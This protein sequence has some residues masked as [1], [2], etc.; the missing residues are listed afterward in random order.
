M[1]RPALPVLLIVALAIG[2]VP[3]GATTPLVPDSPFGTPTAV[4]AT[5]RVAFAPA[6]TEVAAR[7][8]MVGRNLV[9]AN[10]Q[11]GVRPLFRT[12]GSPEPEIFHRGT[13]EI[14]IS[15]GLAKQC[16]TDA[17]LTAVLSHELGKLVS[18][19]EALAGPR[20]R[21]SQA[22]PPPDVPVGNLDGSFSGAADQTRLAELARYKPSAYRGP[23]PPPPDPEELAKVYLH[24]AG[25][26][27]EELQAVAPWLKAAAVNSTLERQLAPTGTR[28][29][30]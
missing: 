13:T 22:A 17:Q 1:A 21:Q 29:T 7:V 26:P 2:C 20:A 6:S 15:E 3:D 5:A 18:E 28:A 27:L 8:D 14:Y 9:A 12:I 24:R 11:T 30:N 4:P 25:V 10:P 16:A 19:R 23:A